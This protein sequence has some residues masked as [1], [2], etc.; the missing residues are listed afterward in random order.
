MARSWGKGPSSGD[1]A[2][3]ESAATASIDSLEYVDPL[4]GAD[5]GSLTSRRQLLSHTSRL[6]EIRGGRWVVVSGY[7]AP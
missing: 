5:K 2:R 4:F 3:D 6:S 1:G 7:T